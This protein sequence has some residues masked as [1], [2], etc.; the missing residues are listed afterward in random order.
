MASTRIGHG[1]PV[2]AEDD[3]RVHHADVGPDA[4]VDPSGGRT[5]CGQRVIEVYNDRREVTC[6]ICAGD[7]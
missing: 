1:H 2:R 7:R 3:D 6:P 4:F 5:S